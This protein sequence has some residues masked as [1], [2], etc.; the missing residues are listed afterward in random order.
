LFTAGF[1]WYFGGSREDCGVAR[2]LAARAHKKVVTDGGSERWL[3]YPSDLKLLLFKSKV[4]T[5]S[6][7]M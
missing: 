5:F 6:S 7:G 1:L 4:I 2:L 3:N